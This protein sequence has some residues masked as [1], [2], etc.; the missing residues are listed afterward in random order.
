[1]DKDKIKCGV[2]T[3]IEMN[4]EIEALKAKIEELTPKK[5]GRPKK[6]DND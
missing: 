3:L 5:P 2:S 6:D 4:R 1:M